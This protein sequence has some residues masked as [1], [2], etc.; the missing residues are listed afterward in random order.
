AAA[1]HYVKQL[2]QKSPFETILLHVVPPPDYEAAVLEAG[3][4]VLQELMDTRRKLGLDRLNS[5]CTSELQ[6][7]PV[8]RVLLEGFPSD[9]IVQYAT[10]REVDLIVLPT[11]G[12][13]PFRRFLLGSV[14]SKVLHDAECAVLTGAHMEEPKLEDIHFSKI[15]AAVDLSEG[16][17]KVI[18]E[19]KALAER[20][21]ATLVVMHAMA[22]LS[23]HVG[24]NFEKAHELHFE[25]AVKER[26]AELTQGM[27]VE[28]LIETG[29]PGKTIASMVKA[30]N[31][32]L[33]VIARSTS[34]GLAALR[35]YTY[36]II[37][38]SGVPVMSV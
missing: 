17:A 14:T 28:T 6:G 7:M 32:D 2:Y 5:T 11:H 26:L 29:D 9:R 27:D 19:A 12:Y 22:G 15:A 10:E 4:P 30:S 25:S 35:S 38:E 16:S 23:G 24:F 37:R 36:A 18:A 21:G 13:G 3:G 8:E 1:A 34:H 20:F 31:T 33:V